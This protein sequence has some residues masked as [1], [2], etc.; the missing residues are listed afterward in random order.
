[1]LVLQVQQGQS[2][3]Y[4]SYATPLEYMITSENGD[5]LYAEPPLTATVRSPE[6]HM[7]R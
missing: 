7:A 6:A 4:T 1:M 3:T 5:C 2:G